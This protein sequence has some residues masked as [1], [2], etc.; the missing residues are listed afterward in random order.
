MIGQDGVLTAAELDTLEKYR[1]SELFR[2]CRK[3]ISGEYARTAASLANPSRGGE[4]PNAIFV[5]RGKLQGI[6]ACYNLLLNLKNEA[7]TKDQKTA[8]QNI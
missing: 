5:A 4:D 3:V 6:S 1:D 2:I 7:P 8:S